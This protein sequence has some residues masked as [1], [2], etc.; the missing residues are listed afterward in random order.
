MRLLITSRD[1]NVRKACRMETPPKEYRIRGI[2]S[3][4]ARDL[5][6]KQMAAA[7]P[8]EDE[9]S[10]SVHRIIDRCH[11]IPLMLNLVVQELSSAKDKTEVH[12]VIQELEKLEGEEFGAKL[13][14]YFFLYDKLPQVCKEPFLDICSFFIGWDW[15]TVADIVGKTALDSLA[16]RSLVAKGKDGAV[17]VPEVIMKVGRR[18]AEDQMRMRFPETSQLMTFLLDDEKVEQLRYLIFKPA[19]D[20]NQ[21]ITK[22]LKMPQNLKY[23]EIDGKFYCDN[24][25]IFPKGLLRLQELRIL[26]LFNFKGLKELPSVLGHLVKGFREL[27]LSNCKSIKELPYSISMLRSLRVLKMDHC[28]DLKYLPDDFASLN[29]LEILCI[30]HCDSLEE[31]PHSFEDLPS[32]TVLNLSSCTA[33]KRLPD[34]L[35]KITS[36][37][38]LDVSHCKDLNSLPESIQGCKSLLLM[39]ISWCSSLEQLPNEFCPP[40]HHIS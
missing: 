9:I 38:K 34:G 2:S 8:V 6:T 4:D 1:R 30:N 14:S 12:E 19:K 11:G 22:K 13:D 3:G 29:S 21:L 33:L 35:G 20:W 16:H 18:K 23:M 39:D 10:S 26:K 17:T 36:L 37:V 31:L 7:A 32:L 25:E 27:T 28:K 40:L 15:D 24:L 5:L